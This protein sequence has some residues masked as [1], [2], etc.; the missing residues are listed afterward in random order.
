M[1]RSGTSFA[2][3]ALQI[4]GASLGEPDQLMGIGPDNPVGYWENRVIK[5]LDDELLGRLGG[6]WDHPPVLAAG[7]E[8]DARLDELRRQA[9]QTLID[10]FGTLDDPDRV[11]AWKDPRL[12]IVLPFW[13]T[14]TDVTATVVLVRHPEAVAASL[15]RRNGLDRAQSALLWVRYLLAAVDTAPN[16]LVLAQDRFFDDL[17]VTLETLAAHAALPAPTPDMIDEVAA[18]LDPALIHPPSVETTT[19]PVSF[20]A[21]ELWNDGDVTTE[22]LEG[23]LRTCLRDG[24]LRPPA[25]DDL[26]TESRA[27]TVKLEA[28]I[29]RRSLAKKRLDAERSRVRGADQ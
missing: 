19:D 22:P 14:V 12:A 20:L 25:D 21:V 26:L 5:E 24:W 29:R 1:H 10:A 15:E 4:L 18:H 11:I 3:R 7:W 8:A 6:S 23:S 16:P 9:A 27:K 13:R 2:T 28:T 17:A